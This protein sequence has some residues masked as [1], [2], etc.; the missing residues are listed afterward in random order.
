MII[1][2]SLSIF[3]YRYHLLLSITTVF[4]V[5]CSEPSPPVPKTIAPSTSTSTSISTPTSTSPSSTVP[6]SFPVD[7]PKKQSQD[8]VIRKLDSEKIRRGEI[9][10]QANCATCHGLKGEATTGWR[11]KGADGKYPPPPLNGSAHAWHH[12]TDTMS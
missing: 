10:Y 1:V 4:V 9:V 6:K 2:K 11:E 8:M 5:G 12:S 3:Y 7:E